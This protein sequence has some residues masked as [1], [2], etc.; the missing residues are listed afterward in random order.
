MEKRKRRIGMIGAGGISHL[1]CQGWTRLDDCEL[2]AITDIN[3]AA[4]TKRAEEFT[5]P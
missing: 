2:V 1:H 4:A 5:T 3:P